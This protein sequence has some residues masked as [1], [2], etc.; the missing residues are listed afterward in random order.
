MW[1]ACD[2]QVLEKPLIHSFRNGGRKTSKC[3]NCSTARCY[4]M[5]VSFKCSC[6]NHYQFSWRGNGVPVLTCKATGAWL[7]MHASWLRY[8]TMTLCERITDGSIP[9]M[10]HLPMFSKLD[11]V[12]FTG[13]L[14]AQMP[15]RNAHPYHLHI[16]T[17]SHHKQIHWGNVVLGRSPHLQG[18]CA[19]SLQGLSKCHVPK[20]LL[21]LPMKR[22]AA[23]T[24]GVDWDPSP[25]TT[26]LVKRVKI[27]VLFQPGPKKQ[28]ETCLSFKLWKLHMLHAPNYCG[29]ERGPHSTE[30]SLESS[31]APPECSR[32]LLNCVASI[33]GGKLGNAKPAT[34]AA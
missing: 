30:S 20:I 8:L 27:Q 4:L 28:V 16:R 26:T 22:K 5:S 1:V 21:Q 3:N 7:C 14:W 9:C 32:S 23:S 17:K 33:D 25:Q 10:T 2:E 19:V 13:L 24:L 11:P 15:W 34:C 18:M 6:F 31:T 29:V 12:Q